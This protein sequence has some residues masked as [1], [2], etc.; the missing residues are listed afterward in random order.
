V[1]KPE[2]TNIPIAGRWILWDGFISIDRENNVNALKSIVKA[3]HYIKN[4]VA[5][6][7][8][9]PEGTRSKT[10]VMAPFKPGSFKIATLAKCPIVVVS[11]QNT[12]YL[13]KRWPWRRTHLYFDVL[14]TIEPQ[15]FAD[16]NTVALA[17]R[18]QKEI[19]DNLDAHA[20]REYHP[21]KRGS[22]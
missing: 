21:K 22:R 8:I 13:H 14:E 3:V 4:N 15:E 2:N 19:Q 1:T 6:V 5:S 18:A 10:G 11:I 17:E 16:G 9:A 7:I 12:R 20:A